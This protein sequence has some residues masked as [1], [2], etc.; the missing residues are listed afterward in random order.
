MIEQLDFGFG[1]SVGG[2][3]WATLWINAGLLV[4]GYVGN[5][6]DIEDNFKDV[7]RV[8]FCEACAQ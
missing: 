1:E 7:C 3:G 2:V 4:V 5:L 8:K 6:D